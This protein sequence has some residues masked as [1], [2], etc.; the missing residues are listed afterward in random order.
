MMLLLYLASLFR[1]DAQPKTPW[2]HCFT[3]LWL[4]WGKMM[5]ARK[6][7]GLR[8]PFSP[9][10][11]TTSLFRYPSDHVMVKEKVYAWGGCWQSG[12][13][14]KKGILDPWLRAQY[15]PGGKFEEVEKAMFIWSTF[16]FFFIPFSAWMMCT[17]PAQG[18]WL[19]VT[20][21]KPVLSA[22]VRRLSYLPHQSF[23][24]TSVKKKKMHFLGCKFSWISL[25]KILCPCR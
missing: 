23:I 8:P 18:D 16:F 2:R 17:M 21:G 11:A 12:L 24:G 4:S 14:P 6:E 5:Q 1:V 20:A 10:T 22:R 13:A 19:R 25:F 9:R 3:C 7:K 15:R